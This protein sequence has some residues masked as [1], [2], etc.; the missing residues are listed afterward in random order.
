M[1]TCTRHAHLMA[2]HSQSMAVCVHAHDMHTLWLYTHNLWL[3]THN[4]WLYTHTLWLIYG[5]EAYFTHQ[6]AGFLS[7]LQRVENPSEQQVR[8]WGCSLLDL[9]NDVTGRYRFEVFCKKTFCIENVRFWQACRD[10]KT[11]PLVAVNGSVKLI[12]E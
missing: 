3:Y 1:C 7:C 11:L 12:Y 9:L 10:L 2:V 4:L 6:W 5:C 8:K